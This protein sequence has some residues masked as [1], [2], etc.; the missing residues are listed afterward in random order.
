MSKSSY[1]SRF[2]KLRG[3]IMASIK[4]RKW[5]LQDFFSVQRNMEMVPAER[6]QQI[7]N[8]VEVSAYND[9]RKYEE[10][11]G[12]IRPF[13]A[14]LYARCTDPDKIAAIM[15]AIRKLDVSYDRLPFFSSHLCFKNKSSRLL[16]MG[17]NI[18]NEKFVAGWDYADKSGELYDAL[19]NAGFVGPPSPE[20]AQQTQS[21]RQR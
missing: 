13:K 8:V 6:I 4:R 12:K 17:F 14:K 1:F 10:W 20:P 3:Q 16:C 5:F 2:R 11:S 15:K 7:Q 21:S 18:G 9:T 19:Q